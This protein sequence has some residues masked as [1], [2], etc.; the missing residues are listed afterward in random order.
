VT[1]FPQVLH[2]PVEGTAPEPVVDF[3]PAVQAHPEDIR[4]PPEGKGAVG[5]HGNPGKEAFRIAQGIVQGAPTVFPEKG[6]ASLEDDDPGPHLRQRVQS[7]AD[8]IPVHGIPGPFCPAMKGAAL[9]GQVAPPG[10]L[11]ARQEGGLSPEQEAA[12]KKTR[13][14]EYVPH[15]ESRIQ[16]HEIELPVSQYCL[17]GRPIPQRHVPSNGILLQIE[18]LSVR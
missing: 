17:S 6:L 8:R 10:D 15:G 4:R 1:G 7:A 11:E 9:A 13:K 5:R 18:V 12:R 14:I 3:L 16:A 2:D